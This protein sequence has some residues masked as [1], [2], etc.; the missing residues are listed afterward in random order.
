MR[1]AGDLARKLADQMK[2]TSLS[3][4]RAE[5]RRELIAAQ[6]QLNTEPPDDG[7]EYE[8]VARTQTVKSSRTKVKETKDTSPI[9]VWGLQ[10]S[11][12]RNGGHF[13]TYEVQLKEDGTTSC[14]CPGWIFKKTSEDRGCKHTRVVEE[15]AK[16][17]YKKHRNGE[18]LPTV[19]P[20]EAQLSRLANSKAGAKGTDGGDTS[21]KFNR[22][23]D[24]D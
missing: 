23:V 13:I 3:E 24:L 5:E 2:A 4:I 7:L 1:E 17:F 9:Y 20:S 11:K 16:D 10:S 19:A 8:L 15:E 14:N 18:S 22:V 12:P 6:A 21:I